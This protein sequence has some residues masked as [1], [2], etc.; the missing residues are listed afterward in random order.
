MD[1]YFKQAIN[2][3]QWCRSSGLH[4]NVG[5][6]KEMII[7]GSNIP[8]SQPPSLNDQP[9]DKLSFAENADYI[10]VF[11]FKASQRL[12]LIRKLK[13]FVVSQDVLE[14]IY[15]SLVESILTFSMTV[16]CGN[17]SMRSKGKLTRTVNTARK[18]IGWLFHKSTKNEG[19]GCRWRHHPPSTPSVQEASL[20]QVLQNAQK[21]S[22]FKHWLVPCAV[23]LLNA[24]EIASVHVLIYPVQLGQWSF[25]S[26]CIN[27]LY[28]VSVC[29]MMDWVV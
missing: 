22:V 5:K 11:F 26:E 15:S 27:V 10:F 25:V 19:T 14:R 24:M 13:G 12:F 17:L 29:I 1:S 4:L 21:K 16:R 7:N 18:V 3:Q 28:V 6:T 9:V 2:L 23:G 20:W 8:M